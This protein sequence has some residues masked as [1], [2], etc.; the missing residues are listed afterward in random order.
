MRHLRQII[1]ALLI[2][3]TFLFNIER[4]DFGTENIVDIDSF[5]YIL[6]I[7]ASL[8]V[9]ILPVFWYSHVSVSIAFWMGIYLLSKLFIFN[10]RP[11]LGG[12]YTYLSIT[13]ITLLSISIWLSYFLNRAI[14]DF[15]KAVENITLQNDS[16]RIRHLDDALEDVQ[17]EMFRSRHNHHPLSIVVVAPEPE[18]IQQN[19]HQAVQEAQ[20]TMLRSYV[21]NSMAQTLSKYLRRT[22][23]ILEEHHKGRFI[24]LCPDTNRTDLSVLV[25][26]IQSTLG[27][28]LNVS[29]KCGMA[30][31]P[32]EALTFE[33]LV[34]HAE[35]KLDVKDGRLKPPLFVLK[36]A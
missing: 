30:T 35:G 8:L 23:L 36:G 1:I 6:S 12:V 22:D 9:I 10:E 17:I 24:I 7:L 26:Y 3:L 25:E 13:E 11:L 33:E 15:E 21:I 29:V 19:L 4:L 34:K 5:V 27:E 2:G 32:D 28:V 16:R 31:F 18:S 20:Q 14:R